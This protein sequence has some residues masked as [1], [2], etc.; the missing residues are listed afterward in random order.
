[1]EDKLNILASLILIRINIIICHV[2]S[3]HD[4]TEK[5]S[6]QMKSR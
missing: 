6:R 1:M 2:I 5:I 4:L 3:K